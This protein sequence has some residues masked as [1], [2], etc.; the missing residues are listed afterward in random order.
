MLSCDIKRSAIAMAKSHGL[1][2][3]ATQYN[4]PIKSLKRWLKVGAERK[5]G[6]GRK[7]KDPAME[8]NLHEWY[9]RKK[10]SD[11]PIT[12]KMVKSKAIQ[13][14]TIADFIASKGWL[15]KFK[16][17]FNL[18]LKKE[19]HETMDGLTVSNQI[20]EMSASE[21]EEMGDSNEDLTLTYGTNNSLD[22]DQPE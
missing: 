17:R 15:D 8:Q 12:A 11:I 2:S 7:T 21:D 9:L 22:E 16:V 4:V 20:E 13:L 5:K 3:A 18:E 6:G 10:A 14:S 1:R 19:K